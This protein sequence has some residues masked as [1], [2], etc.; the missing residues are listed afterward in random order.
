MKRHNFDH[1]ILY[2]GSTDLVA[3]EHEKYL[4]FYIRIRFSVYS[5]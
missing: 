3:M 1:I 4:E 5:K 2:T